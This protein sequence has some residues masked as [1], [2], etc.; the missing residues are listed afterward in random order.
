MDKNIN[1]I[2]AILFIFMFS[3]AIHHFVT[4]NIEIEEHYGS[5][6]L[7]QLYAKDPQDTYLTDDAY[8]YLYYYPYGYFNY[9]YVESVWNNPTRYTYGYYGYPYNYYRRN[10]IFPFLWW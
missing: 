10:Y 1:L 5:G 2:L 9:P 8:K 7:V 3:I 6:A 4:Y